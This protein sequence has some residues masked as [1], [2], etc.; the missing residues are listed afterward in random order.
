MLCR[1]IS[2]KDSI[3]RDAYGDVGGKRAEGP[4]Q[5][6]IVLILI[7]AITAINTQAF[8]TESCRIC[9]FR[10]QEE[11]QELECICVHDVTMEDLPE[12]TTEC[13]F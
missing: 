5:F 7:S 11:L 8:C 2:D 10:Y 1:R 13:E 6:N 3:L 12:T 9:G 4:P